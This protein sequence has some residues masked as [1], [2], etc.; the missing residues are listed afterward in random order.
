MRRPAPRNK[1][2][3]TKQFAV[4]KCLRDIMEEDDNRRT[5]REVAAL[6]GL[7]E[8]SAKV[9]LKRLLRAGFAHFGVGTLHSD[10]SRAELSWSCTSA[11][12]EVVRR[13]EK[14]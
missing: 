13:W 6:V 2:K 8:N 14:K 9:A 11:G 7:S 5:F 3:H 10:P 1:F 12:A 4:L